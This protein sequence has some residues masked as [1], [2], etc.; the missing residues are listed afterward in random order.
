MTE[1]KHLTTMLIIKSLP[2]PRQKT[3]GHRNVFTRKYH[4]KI[5]PFLPQAKDLTQIRRYSG[6]GKRL[7]PYTD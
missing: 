3:F 6:N 7:F 4:V 1:T 2:Q 5:G